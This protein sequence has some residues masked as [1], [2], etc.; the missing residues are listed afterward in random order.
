MARRAAT[1]ANRSRPWKVAVTGCRRKGEVV[2]STAAAAPPQASR[3]GPRTPLSGATKT[4]SSSFASTA[5]G[6]RSDP[7]PGSITATCTPG[8]AKG[9]A[10]AITTAPWRTACRGSPWVMSMIRTSGAIRAITARQTPANSSA[11]P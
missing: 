10:F 5:T 7:T 1:G 6:R 3:T 2:R 9:T 11:V 4:R 8:S